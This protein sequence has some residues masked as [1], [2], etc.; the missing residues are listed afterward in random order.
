ML[1]SVVSLER[2]ELQTEHIMNWLLPNWTWIVVA[3][4]F[5]FFLNR[6]G[7]GGCGMGHAHHAPDGLDHEGPQTNPGSTGNGARNEAGARR[8]HRHRGC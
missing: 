6:A 8:E 5:L 4:G 2:S 1:R 3:I 7:A